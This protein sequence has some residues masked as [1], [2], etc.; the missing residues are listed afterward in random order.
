MT[1][2][3]TEAPALPSQRSTRFRKRWARFASI[4]LAVLTCLSLQGCENQVGLRD[5]I[6]RYWNLAV[7]TAPTDW[8]FT[9]ELAGGTPD[10]IQVDL[11]NSSGQHLAGFRGT[12][13]VDVPIDSFPATDR[14]KV[15]A[16]QGGH[17]VEELIF[18]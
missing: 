9:A 17:S 8:Q 12:N 6:G 13:V 7:D 4:L 2:T 11:Y 14:I 1:T 10:Y 16:G 3:T 18:L 15:S 5:D